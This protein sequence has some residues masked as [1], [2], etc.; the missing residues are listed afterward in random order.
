MNSKTITNSN[1]NGT[2]GNLASR[3]VIIKI[4][5]V[6]FYILIST[7][8]Y[9]EASRIEHFRFYSKALGEF[10]ELTIYIPKDFKSEN[11]Y[12]VIFCTDG[13][14]INEQYKIKLDSI[15]SIKNIIPF[16][17]VG[18]NSNEKS[19]PD[20]YFEYRNFEY[21]EN[22]PSNN[23]DLSSRFERHVIFFVYEVDEYLKQEMQ[24]KIGNKYFYGVSNGAG[25]G[26]S[27]SK[28]YPN[29]FSKYIL[30]SMAS[31]N[32]KKLKWNAEKYPFFIIRYGNDEPK[33]FKKDN[34]K[35]SKYLSKNHYQHIFEC[36]N[37]GHKRED[38][39]NQFI[40]DIEKL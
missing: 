32:Y 27:I 19:I 2:N 35:F 30:Y 38:W 3:G 13:Q 6:F 22:M 4:L 26:V 16:L 29:L 40:K 15:L 20:S 18:V 33:P 36:Y 23:S 17:M 8:C 14:I 25:F 37:G 7:Y 39:L 28:Y 5:Y 12:N 21:I 11:I 31:G 1:L 34:K 10:R 9:A 24:L